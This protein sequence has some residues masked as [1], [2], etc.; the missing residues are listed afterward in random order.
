MGPEIQSRLK[1]TGV[2]A[3]ALAVAAF[4]GCGG[5]GESAG[6]AGDSDTGEST[7]DGAADTQ[8]DSPGDGDGIDAREQADSWD[9]PGD[10]GWIDTDAPASCERTTTRTA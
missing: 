10:D 9:L 5:G 7:G 4:W 2:L 3:A 6:D 1:K 8:A